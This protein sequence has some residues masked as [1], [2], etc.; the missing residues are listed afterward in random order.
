MT[1]FAAKN[2]EAHLGMI[3]GSNLCTEIVQYSDP[4]HTAVCTLASVSVSQFAIRGGH[5]DF[6]GLREATKIAV[7][8]VDNLI[9]VADYPTRETYLSAIKTRA[10]GVGAQGLADAFM[11]SGLAFASAEARV[12][13]FRIFEAIYVAA[14]TTSCELGR[15]YGSYAFFPD[16]PANSGLLQPDMWPPS[17]LPGLHDFDNIRQSIRLYGLR[18][19]MLTAQMPTASTA[20]LLGNFD[21]VEPYTR[22]VFIT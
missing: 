6:H 14:Y 15:L 9:N 4:D 16:S 5:Y 19:S 20:R 8:G 7:R 12:L 17:S 3:N 21:G 22:Y 13:N 10:L 1:S 2:N 11:I 18:N